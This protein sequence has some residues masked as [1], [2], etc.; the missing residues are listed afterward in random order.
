MRNLLGQLFYSIHR[1]ARES[2]LETQAHVLYRPEI[3]NL[4]PYGWH[5]ET[6]SILARDTGSV[7]RRDVYSP[8]PIPRKLGL[9]LARKNEP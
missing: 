3:D 2:V 8:P 4:R 6:L 9:G 7:C 5:L 1:R